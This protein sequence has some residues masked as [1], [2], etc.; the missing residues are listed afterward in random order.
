MQSFLCSPDTG[1]RH[2]RLR[3][4]QNQ[5]LSLATLF[6]HSTWEEEFVEVPKNGE[7]VDSGARK[8]KAKLKDL[9]ES[10]QREGKDVRPNER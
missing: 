1:Y 10:S 6:V 5:P 3:S 4:P 7:A 8:N 9:A 2:I